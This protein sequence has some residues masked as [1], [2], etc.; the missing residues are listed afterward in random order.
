[1]VA[2]PRLKPGSGWVKLEVFL[3]L[4]VSGRLRLDICAIYLPL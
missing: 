1:M 2:K 4:L 3:S